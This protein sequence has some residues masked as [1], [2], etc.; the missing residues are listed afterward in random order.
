M[1]DR[2][3]QILDYIHHRFIGMKNHRGQIS[4]SQKPLE[5]ERKFMDFIRMVIEGGWIVKDNHEWVQVI[6]FLEIQDEIRES[7]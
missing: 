7:L 2:Y 1:G 4:Q 5:C 6:D 3:N